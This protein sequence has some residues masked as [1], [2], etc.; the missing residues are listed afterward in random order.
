M[1]MHCFYRFTMFACAR[2]A[3]VRSCIIVYMTVIA[4][5]CG[6]TVWKAFGA[7]NML[8]GCGP[9]AVTWSPRVT[10]SDRAES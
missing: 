2:S 5:W 6:E 8:A 1:S 10:G 3:M 7:Q 9:S 4:C